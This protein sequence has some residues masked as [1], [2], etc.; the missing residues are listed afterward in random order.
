[1]KKKREQSNSRKIINT[2]N[3]SEILTKKFEIF[4]TDFL[5]DPCGLPSELKNCVLVDGK[6][7]DFCVSKKTQACKK[8]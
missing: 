7:T 1:M 5:T 2:N 4:V 3:S 8:K 6:N